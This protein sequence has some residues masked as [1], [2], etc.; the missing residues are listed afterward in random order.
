MHK[1]EIVRFDQKKHKS[2][3][4]SITQMLHEAYRPLLEKGMR[5]VA[6]HQ[7]NEVT[8]RRLTRGYGFLAFLSEELVG[9]VSL[10]RNASHTP[11][12]WY[13]Q[14][15]VFFFTQFAVK[16]KFQRKGIGTQLMDHIES[17]AAKEGATEIALDTSEKAK[18]LISLYKKRGYRFVERIDWPETNYKSVVMSKTL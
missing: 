4:P 7:S 18:D 1:I 6:T 5:Y 14:P 16:P 15:E 9:T 11:C 8:L 3:L 17:F 10:I 12:K 13:Q 2:L